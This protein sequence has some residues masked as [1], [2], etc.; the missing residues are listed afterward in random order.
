MQQLDKDM[1][2]FKLYLNG[3]FDPQN[4]LFWNYLHLVGRKKIHN[5]LSHPVQFY[6]FDIEF[7]DQH[8]TTSDNFQHLPDPCLLSDNV[9]HFQV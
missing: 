8:I 6:H 2:R 3:G 5:E 4:N 9:T 1:F 7:W